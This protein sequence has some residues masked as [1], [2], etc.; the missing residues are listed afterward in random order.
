[1]DVDFFATVPQLLQYENIIVFSCSNKYNYSKTIYI[2]SE[3]KIEILCNNNKHQ[4]FWQKPNNHIQGQGCPQCTESKGESK[5]K[6]ILQLNNIYYINSVCGNK[7]FFARKRK[8]K[9]C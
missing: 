7:S 2:D 9:Q 1:M 3:T 8:E 4:P 6:E 5:I